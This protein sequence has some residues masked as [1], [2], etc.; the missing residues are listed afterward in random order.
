MSSRCRTVQR[1]PHPFR[2]TV[3]AARKFLWQTIPGLFRGR[4]LF[5]VSVGVTVYLWGQRAMLTDGSES[6]SEAGETVLLMH[7]N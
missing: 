4:Y 1:L 3:L 5:S 7:G 6:E 2:I